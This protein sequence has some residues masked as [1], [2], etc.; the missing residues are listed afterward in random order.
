M[1]GFAV[2]ELTS[3]DWADTLPGT[4]QTI[5]ALA[6]QSRQAPGGAAEAAAG[7]GH[8]GRDA[9][10]CCVPAG[11]PHSGASHGTQHRQ[12]ATPLQLPCSI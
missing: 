6:L 9:V 12:H 10:A 1:T 4:N 8:G 3:S 7:A 5:G 2:N 11:G